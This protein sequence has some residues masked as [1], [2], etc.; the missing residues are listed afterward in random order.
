LPLSTARETDQGAARRF[1]AGIAGG[2]QIRA[3]P[4]ER[5]DEQAEL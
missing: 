2:Q 5:A 3:L 4:P 1:Q